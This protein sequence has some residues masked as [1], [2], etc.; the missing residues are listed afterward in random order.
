M[1]DSRI[2]D[3]QDQVVPL[4]NYERRAMNNYG[5]VNTYSEPYAFLPLAVCKL[6]FMPCMLY[7]HGK[8]H[9]T[10]RTGCVDPKVYML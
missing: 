10:H 9:G 1:K 8:S 3:K 7:S 6:N 5:S 2:E 4:M